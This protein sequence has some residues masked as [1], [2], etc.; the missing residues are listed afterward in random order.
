MT[1]TCSILCDMCL[2]SLRSLGA[3]PRLGNSAVPSSRHL[4]GEAL[5]TLELGALRAGVLPQGHQTDL[6]EGRGKRP[7]RW[8]EP[9]SRRLVAPL[10]CPSPGCAHTHTLMHMN[11]TSAQAHSCTQQACPRAA[12]AHNIHVRVTRMCALGCQDLTGPREVKLAHPPTH[13]P[14][15]HGPRRRL[16][17][18]N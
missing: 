3:G 12:L 8:G 18:D 17:A 7:A 16:H 13:C 10:T 11:T 2:S 9:H 6:T 5:G 14:S 15:W 4:P 1:L